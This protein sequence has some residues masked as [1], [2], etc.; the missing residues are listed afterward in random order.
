MKA[1]YLGRLRL[2]WCRRCNLPLLSRRCNL[3]GGSG[4]K[5]AVTPP[6]DVRPAFSRD[7]ELINRTSRERFG[8]P[9]LREGELA[10]LNRAPG[11]DAL[12]EVIAGGAV[13]GTL[14]Y[15][16][17]R[18]YV[19][20]PSLE[21]AQR[22]VGGRSYVEVYPEVEQFLARGASVLLPGVKDF[23]AAIERGDEVIVTCGGRVIGVG[24]ARLSGKEAASLE[25]GMFVKLRRQGTPREVAE[26]SATWEQAVEANLRVISDYEREAVRFIREVA[27]EVS[28]PVVVAFSG[29]KDSLATLLLVKKALGEATAMVVDT[30]VEFPETLRFAREAVRAVGAELLLVEA[31]DRFWRGVELFGF[32]ARDYRWCCKVVK[33]GPTARAIKER[34]PEGCLTFIGQRRYE[35]STRA[36][37][38]RVWRNPWLRNQLAASPI[39]NWT[40]LHVWLFLLKEGVKPNP[41][42]EAGSYR[43]GCWLCPGAEMADVVQLRERHPPLW[44][45][46]R[47]VLARQ[48]F[49]EAEFLHGLWRWRHLPK[50][51]RSVAERLGAGHRSR[52]RRFVYHLERGE[53][54]LAKTRFS[55]PFEEVAG[56]ARALGRPREGDGFIEVAS[57]RFY[58]SGIAQARAGNERELEARVRSMQGVIERAE[59]CLACGVCVAQC[60]R[61]A[62]VVEEKARIITERCTSCGAC[63]RRCPLVRY[64]VAEAEVVFEDAQG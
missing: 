20:L 29:G 5:V 49:G 41:L 31:G 55:A 22:L 56:F 9:L 6:G 8:K 35:S 42:Y 39:Q 59:H 38:Q 17:E 46:L 18:G 3:C 13:L 50:A 54:V 7:V 32:P 64:L 1:P 34:F 10:L 11:E 30:G 16:F 23:D 60:R 52:R 12:D 43:L 2:R 61:D 28:K 19:L 4:E 53:A 57:I 47:D 40:A 48:G 63:H 36:A 44:E 25:K 33:L 24:R 15:D 62:I 58:R 21:G 37:S 27:S 26:G 14:R 45:K 51:Q